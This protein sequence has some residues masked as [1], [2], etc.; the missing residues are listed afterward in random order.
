MA[1]RQQLEG[2]TKVQLITEAKRLGRKGY[3]G[4]KNEELV[5]LILN[6]PTAQK[7]PGRPKGSG[8]GKGKQQQKQQGTGAPRGRPKQVPTNRSKSVEYSQ[9]GL[10]DLT[11]PTLKEL[12]RQKGVTGYSNKNKNDI[13]GLL[14]N[15]AHR[16]SVTLSSVKDGATSTVTVTATALSRAVPETQAAQGTSPRGGQRRLSQG[17]QGQGQSQQQQQELRLEGGILP[18]NMQASPQARFSPSRMGQGQ[19]QQ[20]GQGQQGRNSPGRR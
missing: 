15:K 18:L 7:S 5:E 14:L 16:E 9:A 20:M 1:S 19:Q 4:K 8:A 3:S 12:A 17:A 6:P 13:I 2:M 10:S 11:L